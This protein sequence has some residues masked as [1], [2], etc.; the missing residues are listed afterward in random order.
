MRL[1]LV[2][3]VTLAAIV[4]ASDPEPTPGPEEEEQS[5]WPFMLISVILA[6]SIGFETM[7]EMIEERAK[8]GSSAIYEPIT[9][10]LFSELATLGFIGAIAFTLTYNFNSDC[11]GACSV[12]QRLSLKL[13]GESDELQE[14]F[15]ALHFILF[16]VSVVFMFVVFKL[17]HLTTS[18]KKIEKLEKEVVLVQQLA[19][20]D[21]V[22]ARKNTGA[23]ACSPVKRRRLSK[24]SSSEHSSKQLVSKETSEAF[25]RGSNTTS[26]TQ[27]LLH[28][29]SD[30]MGTRGSDQCSEGLFPQSARWE[31]QLCPVD[32]LKFKMG[33]FSDP[34]SK[35]RWY[36]RLPDAWWV[37]TYLEHGRKGKGVSAAEYVRMRHRFIDDE[38]ECVEF[39]MPHD[40]DFGLYLKLT[41]AKTYAAIIEIKPLD[42]AILWAVMGIVFALFYSNPALVLYIF[43]VVELVIYALFITV[44]N[45][46]V[47]IRR[48]LVPQLENLDGGYT[49]L[50][51]P[52]TTSTL[53]DDGL[54]DDCRSMLKT[55][56]LL[57]QAA[58][59]QLSF[60]LK[61][62]QSGAGAAGAAK[63]SDMVSTSEITHA[64]IV[65]GQSLK[66]RHKD[67]LDAVQS[68]DGGVGSKRGS[69][70]EKSQEDKELTK[71]AEKQLL[72]SVAEIPDEI[73]H[74]SGWLSKL[75]STGVGSNSKDWRLR[76]CLCVDGVISCISEK[77][78][79]QLSKQ[80]DLLDCS[81]SSGLV[82]VSYPEADKMHAFTLNFN[83]GKAITFAAHTE[84]D[85]DK[86]LGQINFNLSE[87]ETR[88]RKDERSVAAKTS[89]ILR[90]PS[91]M[92]TQKKVYHD[93]HNYR[94][95]LMG[96]LC[97]ANIN[98]HQSLFWFG[99]R[100]KSVLL[101]SI[102]L[103]L[104]VSCVNI[105]LF[106][107][108]IVPMIL[109]IQWS[110]LGPDDISLVRQIST[111]GVRVVLCVV[112]LFFP[113]ITLKPMPVCIGYLNLTTC[114][115][116]MK[117][118]DEIKQVISEQKTEEL[119]RA[120][121]VLKSLEYYVQQSEII[122][123]IHS[124]HGLLQ[125]GEGLKKNL[126][127]LF[128]KLTKDPAAKAY[129]DELKETF[130]RGDADG[131]GFIERD[132]LGPLLDGMGQ[133]KSEEELD[134]LFNLMDADGSNGVDFT[135]F[136]TVML[137]SRKGR[138]QMTTNVLAEKVFKIFDTDGDGK[139]EVEEMIESIEAMGKGRA[140]D[141][142]NPQTE[143]VR[144]F[145]EHIDKDGN[146]YILHNDFITVVKVYL[147]EN[148]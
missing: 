66:D 30:A 40:F 136:A 81:H 7:K 74:V 145:L 29:A 1:P 3:L 118:D 133:S 91:Y 102:K 120:S 19:K 109:E 46:L 11:E 64:I 67:R 57:Q 96:I 69:F 88:K 71:I 108:R 2:L 124:N 110:P 83:D 104:F 105:S 142:K 9:D 6:L 101:H 123:S 20:K 119:Q 13:V 98:Q 39:A 138:R 33:I 50:A 63:T 94:G 8:E 103:V 42:W 55:V 131:S 44:F 14:Q 75:N 70:S 140:R 115:E 61:S 116:M 80:C 137:S 51:K 15:E 95:R 113:Y 106:F 72:E 59:E 36:S 141:T 125:D 45:K 5:G 34:N 77:N 10:A 32:K 143:N 130:D 41:L 129:S 117:K 122:A 65:D 12:M 56:P 114:T 4:K 112:G 79:G 35:D 93:K 28:S 111:W 43:Y 148:L 31:D 76:L 100:G 82:E 107:I 84:G 27:S 90:A 49:H 146:G 47:K 62:A 16:A 48:A 23:S 126:E 139:I 25:S 21:V 89:V 37:N 127:T 26:I 97:G 73:T 128:E 132:E 58:D 68:R 147:G 38:D 121:Q 53:P 85:K 99:C 135:E 87:I 22:F 144:V 92:E 134:R 78:A 18:D 86:W 52:Q 54:R 17:L 24:A 60:N